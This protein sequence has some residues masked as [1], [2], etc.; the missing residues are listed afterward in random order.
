MPTSPGSV[1][2]TMETLRQRLGRRPFG[3][4]RHTFRWGWHVRREDLQPES[5]SDN[6]RL[7]QFREFRRFRARPAQQRHISHRQHAV[8][9]ARYPWDLYWQDEFRASDSLTLTFGVRY[10]SPSGDSGTAR[11]CDRLPPRL[12]P[13]D[14]GHEP[15]SSI[16][17][18]RLHGPASDPVSPR[19]RFGFPRTASMPTGTIRPHVRLR[20]GAF[21][22][23]PH[24]HPRRL[25]H[26]V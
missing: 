20:M 1:S 4:S 24:C 21:T 14:R 25:S 11:K 17:T 18:L 13:D 3:G 16:S 7:R 19:R 8:L 12:R 15:G 26:V 9:L 10:E 2:N 23:R 5:G 22:Q 6:A